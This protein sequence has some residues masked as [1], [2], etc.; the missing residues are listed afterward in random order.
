MLRTNERHVTTLDLRHGRIIGAAV[1]GAA[2]LRPLLPVETVPPCPLRA[3]TGLPCPLC[4]MT[5]GVTAA[6]HG[7][8][9]ESLLLTPAALATV[10]AAALLVLVP[11]L[12]RRV[13]VPVWAVFAVLGVMWAYQLLKYATGQ[14]L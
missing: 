9:V 5:R 3:V 1:L 10:V 12:N 2:A 8:L 6:V 13:R 14:P 11:R 7:D 4:G